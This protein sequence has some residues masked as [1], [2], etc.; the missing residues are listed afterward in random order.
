[1]L[2][3]SVIETV[4]IMNKDYF[5]GQLSYDIVSE[6]YSFK[7]N[8]EINDLKLYPAEF[9]GLFELKEIEVQS[10]VIRA[11]IVNR[12]IPYNRTNLSKYLKYYD[13]EFWENGN[14]F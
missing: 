6:E 9:Y 3:K 7:R 11:F 2:P 12:I 10:D 5:L 4:D 1:M 8:K 13:M 14:C